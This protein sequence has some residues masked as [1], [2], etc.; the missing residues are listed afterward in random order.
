MLRRLTIGI[1]DEPSLSEF[2]AALRL[3]TAVAAQYRR[4]NVGIDV[5]ALADGQSL[6]EVASAPLERQAV[7]REGPDTGLSLQGGPGVPVLT[8]SA[9]AG[10]LTSRRDC[11]RATS[12]RWRSAAVRWWARCGTVRSCPEIPSPC[13]TSANPVSVRSRWRRR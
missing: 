8:V 3:G 9:P 10:E 5:V 12:A 2:D 6:P 7:I 4:Q 1:P 11:W 13:G